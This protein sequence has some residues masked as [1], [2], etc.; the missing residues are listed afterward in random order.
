MGTDIEQCEK[1]DES[2]LR[3]LLKAHAKISLE[4][5][6]LETGSIPIKYIIKNRRLNYLYT[7]L[8]KENEELI[9]EIYC[10]QKANPTE[11]D[12]CKLIE[13][14]EEEINLRLTEKEISQMTERKFKEI[15][16]TK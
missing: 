8:T 16:K 4:A 7:I 5:L 9:K 10:A 13:A 12:Y 11:G 2:L 15:V 6:Y 1:V 14:D 3:G